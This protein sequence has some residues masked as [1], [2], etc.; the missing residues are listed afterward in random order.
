MKK[1]LVLLVVLFM[2]F[3]IAGC[4][5]ATKTNESTVLEN[6][7][8]EQTQQEEGEDNALE[9]PLKEKVTFDIMVR[10]SVHSF[11][12]CELYNRLAEE[13]NVNI[14]WIYL[15]Q[16]NA[17]A[18]LNALFAANNEGDGML[19]SAS[20]NESNISLLAAND[21]LKPL[22]EYI[23]NEEI[24]P[25]FNQRVLSESPKTK[26]YITM[27]DGKIYSLPKYT[28]LEGNYLESPIWINKTWLDNLGLSVPKTIEELESVLTAFKEQDANK[29]GNPDDEIPYI[30][31][32]S[33][34]Y[35][36][37]EA[38]LGLWGIATKDSSLDSYVYVINGKVNFAPTSQAYKD[39]IMTLNRWYKN[40]LIWSECFTGTG[41]TYSA[42]LSGETCVVG[43][44]TTKTPPKGGYSDEYILIEPPKI[45]GYKPLWYRHP[46]R[47]GGKGQFSMTRSAENPE[48][49]MHWIDLF[50]GLENSIEVYNGKVG[51]GRLELENP[52]Y[53]FITPKA[54]ELEKLKEEKPLFT[55][56]IG[57]MPTAYTAEDYKN[58]IVL[59][60]D[61]A[62][63]QSN[64]AIYEKY[65]TTE[66]WPRPYFAEEDATRLNELRTDLFNTVSLKKAEWVT[67]T[68]D[69][70][71]EWASYVKSLKSMGLEEFMKIVQKTYDNFLE[72]IK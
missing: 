71:V 16:D 60:A 24:M 41:E 34:S 56:I 38:L 52:K 21:L 11:D 40:G 39:A 58:R 64:Y 68:S 5:T 28:A 6:S 66:Y 33:H 4:Q 8:A 70:N 44:L 61:Q 7:Q 9:F 19:P 46:G 26:G 57:N 35:S 14:N 37:M 72:N 62:I 23:D 1:F 22:N 49:L 31:L 53:K 18:S 32:N 29:N 45:E 47:L 42:K 48:I 20:I 17:M 50:Y 13:T 2:I 55:D 65:M 12:K 59:S 54:D 3:T 36:H 69:V 10:S 25:N 30:F 67:G 43:C 51:E 15:A 63:Y 27:P